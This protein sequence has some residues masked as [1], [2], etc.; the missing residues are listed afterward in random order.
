MVLIVETLGITNSQGS[1]IANVEIL[2]V[3]VAITFVTKICEKFGMARVFSFGT[4][5]FTV[6]P[7]C[8]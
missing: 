4:L 5:L 7:I 2:V 8:I 6:F 1:W 3:I